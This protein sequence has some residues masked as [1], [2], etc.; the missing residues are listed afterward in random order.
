MSQNKWTTTVDGFIQAVENDEYAELELSTGDIL[1]TDT[2]F[3]G[4]YNP[5]VIPAERAPSLDRDTV[6]C[7]IMSAISEALDVSVEDIEWD[8]RNNCFV[9][10]M[11]RPT[12]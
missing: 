5:V 6:E 7:E 9:P 8:E 3:D 10:Y 4:T 2:E 12:N 1:I 11:D